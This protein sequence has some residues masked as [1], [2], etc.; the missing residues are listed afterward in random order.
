MSGYCVLVTGATG[1]IGSEVV[2]LLRAKG[3]TVEALGREIDMTRP[4]AAR[5]AADFVKSAYDGV[6]GFIH[7]A[8]FDAPAPL[9]LVD[10]LVATDLYRI[11]A[12]FPMLFLGW[13]AKKANHAPGAAAVLVSSEAA[14][15][16]SPGHA[17]YA[18]AKGALEAMAQ[19]AAEELDQKGVR[20]SVV[21][22]GPVDSKMTRKWFD[23]TPPEKRPPLASP[24]SAAAKIVEAFEN[25]GMV[26]KIG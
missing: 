1:A 12:L 8:G 19:A 5:E 25:G 21:T 3:C 7:L 14:H 6:S 11:H 24:Q 26:W 10:S 17:A 16:P 4:E 18:A 15:A 2:K 20:L 23:K 13:M 22:L 9:G